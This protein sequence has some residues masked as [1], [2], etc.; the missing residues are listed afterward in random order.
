MRVS[1]RVSSLRVV[2]W[3][4]FRGVPSPVG[5]E[6]AVRSVASAQVGARFRHSGLGGKE[7][8]VRIIVRTGPWPGP[9][10]RH[11]DPSI[12]VETIRRPAAAGP[13]R[14]GHAR[15]LGGGP[16]RRADLRGRRAGGDP[17]LRARRR[18]PHRQERP[19]PGL[20][21]R[22]VR[23]GRRPTRSSRIGPTRCPVQRIVRQGLGTVRLG[24]PDG[25]SVA[26]LAREGIEEH[27]EIRGEPPGEG[28]VVLHAG[29]AQLL[30]VRAGDRLAA[31]GPTGEEIELTVVGTYVSP[32]RDD[33]YWFGS[34]NPFPAPDSTQPQPARRDDRHDRERDRRPRAH[35]P[36][37]VGRVPR[38]HG[39]AVRAGLGRAGPGRARLLE[40]AG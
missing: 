22:H 7:P 2:S 32:D 8:Q 36:V 26:I 35:D 23:L 17:V 4:P 10:V 12:P 24:S 15:V 31:I 3:R 29:V 11:G 19:A 14:R 1:C 27:L 40:P 20:R 30:G 39:R 28:E 16:R 5:N 34:Q 6:P 33:P 25:P 9:E 38:P 21:E 37:L 13:R 18:R